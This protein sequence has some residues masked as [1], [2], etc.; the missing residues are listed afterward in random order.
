M[1]KNT[2]IV[3]SD[4]IQSAYPDE[5]RRKA[6]AFAVIECFQSIPCDPCQTSCKRDAIFPMKDIN[7]LPK[8]NFDKCNGCGICVAACPGLA[9]FIVDET[10]SNDE[11]LVK[12]P[13]EFLPLPDKGDEAWGLDRE[14]KK[15]CKVIVHN[16]LNTKANDRTPIISLRVP[17]EYAMDVRFFAKEDDFKMASEGC[18]CGGKAS[19]VTQNNVNEYVCRCEEITVSDIKEVI[20]KGYTTLNE[21]KIVTR[22]GMG[23]CQGR[24]CRGLIMNI[25]ARETKIDPKDMPMVTFRPPVKPIKMSL[26]CQEEDNYE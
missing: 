22:A 20:K 15:V 1:L 11:A 9:I 16:V 2:G 14:G 26:L 18:D 24:T 7:D 8:I 23:A 21:I 6:G 4:L 3:T 12:I 17:K 10:F 5:K 13:Y 19:I 25:I